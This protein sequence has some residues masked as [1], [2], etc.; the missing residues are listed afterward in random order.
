MSSLKELILVA[1]GGGLGAAARFLASRAALQWMP[2]TFPWGTYLINVS[3][4]L[5][6]GFVAGL[7]DSGSVSPLARL[8][9]VTGVLGGYTT[10]SAFG[11]EAQGLISAGRLS[12]AFLYVAGQILLGL[13]GVF[14]GLSL[15]RRIG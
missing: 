3:G 1:A 15:A 2:T 10:F 8:F 5:M 11:L 7:A 6:I 4:C 12:S 13:F 14:V 9:I